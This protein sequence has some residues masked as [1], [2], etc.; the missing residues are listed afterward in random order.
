MSLAGVGSIY[1]VG[2]GKMG[3]AMAR[4]WLAAGLDASAL[5]LIDPMAGVAAVSFG[6]D[7]GVALVGELPKTA[8]RV[9]VL[10]VKPQ[11]MAK[12]FPGVRDIIDAQTL[13]ISIAAG[14]NIAALSAGAGTQR[15]V[16]TMPNT[17]AQVGKGITGI[18]VGSGASSADRTLVEALLTANGEVVWL[19][20]EAD[21]DAQTAISGCGPAYVFHLV[22]AMAAAGAQAGLPADQAMKLARQTVI[23]AAALMEADP[24]DAAKLRE[25]VTSPGGVTAE[26][27]RV[28]MGEGGFTDLMHRAV[29]AAIAKNRELGG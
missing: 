19:S 10:A 14:I 8:P 16:R 9:L 28:L 27:L 29:A 25:N 3:L 5:H 1:L 11:V 21:L 15:V 20:S 2:A 12:V 6:Q 22:E 18:V 23:G 13:V 7:H 24:S 17:P 26:A 4:G